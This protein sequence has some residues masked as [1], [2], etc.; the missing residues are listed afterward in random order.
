MH[1]ADG[2][3]GPQIGFFYHGQ[4]S[5]PLGYLHLVPLAYW[6]TVD[7]SAAVLGTELARD[8]QYAYV[9][10]TWGGSCPYSPG[11]DY[12]LYQELRL[13]QEEEG[14]IVLAFLEP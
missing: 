6:E 12:D 4:T 10:A 1:Y 11:Q 13:E 3:Q 8:G 9:Y 14:T 2:S 5:A 7:P